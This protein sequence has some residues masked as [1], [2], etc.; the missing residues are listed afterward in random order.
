MVNEVASEEEK[1]IPRGYEEK[2]IKSFGVDL[3]MNSNL[4]FQYE[5]Q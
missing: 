2:Q 3:T 4:G 5:V 1:K